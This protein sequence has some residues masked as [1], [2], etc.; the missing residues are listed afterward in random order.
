MAE[1]YNTVNTAFLEAVRKSIFYPVLKVELLDYFENAYDE[2]TQ[3][4][5]RGNAGS[6]SINYQQG[7]RR[8][9][10]ITVLN[11]FKKYLPEP[12]GRIWFNTKFKVYTGFKVF[13][14]SASQNYLYTNMA[15]TVPMVYSTPVAPPNHFI[16]TTP[17]STQMDYDI[18]WFSQGVFVLTNP[19]VLEDRSNTTV[20]LNG[21]DK[22]G[23]LGGETNFHE[24]EGTY[25]IPMG[26]PVGKCIKDTLALSIGNAQNYPIDPIEPFIDSTIIQWSYGFIGDGTTSQFFIDSMYLAG[27]AIDKKK[28]LDSCLKVYKNGDLLQNEFAPD[29]STDPHRDYSYNSKLGRIT[30]WKEG[31][32]TAPE[33]DDDILVLLDLPISELTLPYDLEKSPNEY[34]AD[35]FV[36]L[37]NIFSCDVF[38]DTNGVFNFIKGNQKKDFDTMTSEWDFSKKDNNYFKPSLSVDFTN[39]YNVIKVVGTN[40]GATEA[41]EYTIENKDLSSPTCVQMIGKKIKYVESSFCYNQAR[42]KDFATYLMKKYS[43]VQQTLN[44]STCMLPQL[45]VNKI[46]TITDDYFNWTEARFIIQSLTIPLSTNGTIEIEASNIANIPFYEY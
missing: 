10:E 5:N 32:Q 2:I 20:T 36:E 15:K 18:Y 4:L 38:Y 19:D 14:Q 23:L 31:V 30:F 21:V 34:F 11:N 13:K 26:T 9:C 27:T 35:I 3:D 42:T 37:G 43:M 28:K 16:S 6:I 1:Y 40:E 12:T 45:D 39:M 17:N 33:A 44:F 25:K 7:V 24:L 8:T 29:G 41:C 46:I 22:F